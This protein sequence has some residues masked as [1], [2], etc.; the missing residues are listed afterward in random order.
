ML[1]L[2]AAMQVKTTRRFIL[3]GLG[4]WAV[5][6]A[7][8]AGAPTTSLRPQMR[9][10][11]GRA[12]LVSRP[13]A[14]LT[15][16][17]M[18]GDVAWSVAD[19]KTGLR[20]EAVNGE[21]ALPPA[22]VAK[23]LTALYALETLGS[24]FRFRTRVYAAGPVRNGILDG[25]LILAGDGDPTLD[26]DALAELAGQLKSRGLREVRGDFLVYDGALPYV[27]TIDEGQP[28]H[29]GYSPA[30]SGI[31]LN[32]NRVHFE[33]K[34][35]SSGY[36]VSMDARTEKYRPEVQTAQMRVVDRKTPVYTYASSG[37]ADSWTVAAQ[38]LGSG[39]SR[40]LPV[41]RPADYAGDVFRTLAR[42]NGVVLKQAK[43]V[44]R[45]PGGAAAL[46]EHASPRLWV[47]LQ[48]MLK[49]SN[50]LTAEMV[51]MT[52]SAAR[53]G[54][55]P[56]SLRSSA[57]QMSRWAA[58]RFDMKH[59]DLVDHSGL[60]EDSRMTADDLVTALV[61]ARRQ[62]VLQ[63]LLKE[64]PVRDEKGR[65]LRDAPIQ[66]NAKT[67]TLNFV[68]GLGGFM[69]AADGTEL[70]FAIFAA[71]TSARAKISRAEREVPPGARGWNGQAKAFQQKLIAHWGK[72]Y[73][74]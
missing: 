40:W 47:I 14:M 19:V 71:D 65:V 72:A 42:S 1:G 28:D 10:P 20:L 37:S 21:L 4:S 39:G 48:G 18:S 51:G 5:A 69:T 61:E 7:A 16:A 62:G 52:A 43:P 25:D 64:I 11:G 22:S 30:V 63:A 55:P 54:G 31:A 57:T 29:L 33:W 9:Q 15:Q 23:T 34:R 41:R 50:N 59:V 13:E 26:T 36:A 35:A 68:S 73:G 70:A 2:S 74:S 27:R 24:D 12:R 3:A 67:G 53:R 45:L 56:T 66:V 32:Y 46:A 6:G 49:H 38:A 17:R 8:Y 60:G 44:G 58:R